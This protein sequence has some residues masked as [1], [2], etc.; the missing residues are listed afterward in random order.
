MSRWFRAYGEVLNDP[1]VQCLPL[2]AFK[3]WHNA[4]SL[5]CNLNSKDGKIGTLPEIAFAFR[6][7]KESVSSAFHPLIEGGLIVTVDETFQIVSWKK[8]QYK[9]DTSTD[10]VK[11]FRDR[12]RNVTETAPDTDTDTDTLGKPSVAAH[13]AARL[14]IGFS[15]PAEWVEW[16]QKEKSW[17]VETVK[18][19]ADN[20][21]D[22]W[23][24]KSGRDATKKD[25]QATWRNWIRNS[26]RAPGMNGHKPRI[27]I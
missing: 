6:E 17:P 21:V 4:L 2:D 23:N 9:S 1:K 14:P 26:R 3:A 25:W 24:A 19:E 8:R 16:A 7:T 13:R 10:R 5:A 11:R 12:S 22:F 15:L 20:F 27:P 18:I